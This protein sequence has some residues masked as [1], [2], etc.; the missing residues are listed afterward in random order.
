M[1]QSAIP[2]P[3]WVPT[4]KQTLTSFLPTLNTLF[5]CLSRLHT[6]LLS[7]IC[8]P[9]TSTIYPLS[10]YH[11]PTYLVNTST[12]SL[13]LTLHILS[14]FLSHL[15]N[16]HNFSHS[17]SLIISFRSFSDAS[18]ARDFSYQDFKIKSKVIKLVLSAARVLMSMTSNCDTLGIEIL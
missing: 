13:S 10:T 2:I 16:K 8:Q 7:H 12:Y 11:L 3:R 1:L 17:F 18:I 5:S 15:F 14:H 4:P 9:H 6:L